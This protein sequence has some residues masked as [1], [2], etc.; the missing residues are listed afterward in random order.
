MTASNNDGVWNE[1]GASLDFSVAPAYYQTSWFQ[2]SCAAAFLTF[3][4]GIY[5]YRLGEIA[6][7]FN[8]RLEERVNERTRRISSK[9][10]EQPIDRTHAVTLAVKR[11]IIEL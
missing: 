3:L 6:R 2:A 5:R 9:S 10:S 1:A 8:V 11:G 7:E 4:W